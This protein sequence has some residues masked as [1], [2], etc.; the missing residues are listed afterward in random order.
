MLGPWPVIH[1]TSSSRCGLILKRL[2]TETP[3]QEHFVPFRAFL[4]KNYKTST[5]EGLVGDDNDAT[6]IIEDTGAETEIDLM[7]TAHIEREEAKLQ[8]KKEQ[9]QNKKPAGSAKKKVKK[10]KS[11]ATTASGRKVKVKR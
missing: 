11:T 2:K 3:L 5:D 9:L 6:S 10:E 8:I 1:Q 7:L 4:G